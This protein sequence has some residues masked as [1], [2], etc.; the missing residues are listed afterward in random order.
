MRR[1]LACSVL[2]GAA[3]ARCAPFD[4]ETIVNTLETGFSVRIA[5]SLGFASLV[6]AALIACSG[7]STGTGIGDGGAGAQTASGTS[8]TSGTGAASGTDHSST[9]ASTVNPKGSAPGE[10]C[11][12]PSDCLIVY[13]D[14]INHSVV[15]SQRCVSNVCQT[16]KSACPGACS[17][18]GTTWS[19][20][21]DLE[22]PRTS[23]SSGSS[24]S[25]G[26]NHPAGQA[27]ASYA[28]CAPY[29]CTCSDGETVSDQACFDGACLGAATGCDTSCAN[30]G[31][32]GAP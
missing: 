2:C 14:C 12:A 4:M 23:T 15:N 1:G 6:S 7:G 21:A 11:N 9:G 22:K 25:S 13:C 24:G 31:H 18:F 17:G 28:D 19:G 27:C 29:T 30:Q 3:G 20:T 5:G 26:T 16:A 10:A 32:G 8:G